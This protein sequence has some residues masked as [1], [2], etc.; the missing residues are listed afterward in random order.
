MLIA[1]HFKIHSLC[2]GIVDAISI[3]ILDIPD[4]IGVLFLLFLS[5]RFD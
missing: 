3:L 4:I 5:L 1:S 2:P